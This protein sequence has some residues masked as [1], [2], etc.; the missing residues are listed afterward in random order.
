MPRFGRN[1]NGDILR[2]QRNFFNIA[3]EL[4]RADRYVHFSGPIFV[5]EFIKNSL[6]NLPV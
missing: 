1:M 5:Y 6:H 3:T 4:S 2:Q